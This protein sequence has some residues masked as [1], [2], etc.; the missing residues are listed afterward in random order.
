MPP[1]PAPAHP[2]LWAACLSFLGLLAISGTQGTTYGRTRTALVGSDALL[3][4]LGLV[5]IV[6][7]VLAVRT[8]RSAGQRVA[9]VALVALASLLVASLLGSPR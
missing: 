3:L 4:S 6:T 7:G 2:L 8:G 1:R 5:C 9:A